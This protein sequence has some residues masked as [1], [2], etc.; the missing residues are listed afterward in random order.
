ML[1]GVGGGGGGGGLPPKEPLLQYCSN[2][3]AKLAF[4]AQSLFFTANNTAVGVRKERPVKGEKA[5]PVNL[6]FQNSSAFAIRLLL[7][8][9]EEAVDEEGHTTVLSSL[10]Q[11]VQGLLPYDQ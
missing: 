10:L 7:T 8:E 9:F 6:I 2:P 5:P 1:G 11:S 4:M 3:E